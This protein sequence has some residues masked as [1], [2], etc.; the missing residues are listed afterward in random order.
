MFKRRAWDVVVP[1]GTSPKSIRINR[2]TGPSVKEVKP[3]QKIYIIGGLGNGVRSHKEGQ[4]PFLWED[5]D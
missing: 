4:K 3:E 5:K 2:V 1:E